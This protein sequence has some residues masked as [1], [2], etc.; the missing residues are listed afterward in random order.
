L[1]Q[2][3]I[4]ILGGSSPLA[5]S[6]AQNLEILGIVS[7]LTHRRATDDYS[8]SS[9]KIAT[10]DVGESIESLVETVTPDLVINCI[11]TKPR[12]LNNQNSW[13]KLLEI[14]ARFPRHLHRVLTRRQTPL[15]LV[16]TDSVFFGLRGGYTE[17]ELPFPRNIYSLSKAMGEIT[18]GKTKVVRL[19]FLGRQKDENRSGGH[20][21]SRLERLPQKAMINVPI[22]YFWNGLD[23][24]TAGKLISNLSLDVINNIDVPAL[25]HLHSSGGLS[26]YQIVKLA[27]SHLGRTD[28]EICKRKL[29][30]PVN[31]TLSSINK[32]YTDSLWTRLGY[33]SKPSTEELL[34]QIKYLI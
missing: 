4:L 34:K 11:V 18:E 2:K 24:N 20:L 28:L 10:F 29:F 16:S 7:T 3:R 31:Y 23:V 26:R 21:V 1:G 12:D 32:K 33:S 27:V 25:S 8:N 19:S 6:I 13:S 9:S 22:N 30:V 17:G 14:N 15:I 5:I